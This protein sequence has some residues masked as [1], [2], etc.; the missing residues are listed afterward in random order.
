[1]KHILQHIPIQNHTQSNHITQKRQKFKLK[2]TK[3]QKISYP[4]VTA[5]TQKKKQTQT[6]QKVIQYVY[7]RSK[8][9]QANK[10]TNLGMTYLLPVF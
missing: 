3:Q 6:K 9:K 8:H 4:C 10:Q 1:M 5:R 7:D 2:K